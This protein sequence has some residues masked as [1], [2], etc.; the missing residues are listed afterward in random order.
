MKQLIKLFNYIGPG[1]ITASAAIGTSHLIQSTR[2]GAYF[3]LE[4]LWLIIIINILKYPFIENGY[5]Y[6]G[7]T[8]KNLLHGYHQLS[9]YYLWLFF[10]IN[11]VATVGGIAVLLY[12]SA[13]IAKAVL[14]LSFSI[15]QVGFV[16]MLVTTGLVV[17]ETYDAFDRLMK[18]F[19]VF[20]FFSTL[21]VVVSAVFNFKPNVAQVVYHTS[22]WNIASLPFVIALMGWMPGPMELGTW[23]SLWLEEKNKGAYKLDYQAAKRDFNIGYGLVILT[24]VFFNVLGALVLHFSGYTISSNGAEFAN[25][26]IAIYTRV[27]G[28]WS[29]VLIGISILTTILSTTF[30]LIDIYP[31]TM[32]ESLAIMCHET[33]E[34]VKSR[35]R[36]LLTII[37]AVVAY[38]VNYFFV[39]DFRTIVDIVTTTAFLFAPFIAYLNYRVVNSRLLDPAYHPGMGL[40]WLSVFGFI[41]IIGF[42]VVFIYSKLM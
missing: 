29:Y 25:Q 41:F 28:D 6:T 36:K 26:L 39:T 13:S 32:A 16:V 8:G 12:V 7:A 4:L 1:I 15:N 33:N 11:L 2:A 34:T 23:H 9:K 17:F 22:A 21:F 18:V 38:L 3:G 40:K 27:M 42:D 20:L 24:A 19:M 35:Q 14:G 10:A 37:S 31:R 30:A 5:R